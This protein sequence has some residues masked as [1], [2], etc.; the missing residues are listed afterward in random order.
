MRVYLLVAGLFFF[1]ISPSFAADYDEDETT[2]NEDSDEDS[3]TSADDEES[4]DE[5]EDSDNTDDSEELQQGNMYNQN[6]MI[7]QSQFIQ[8]QNMMFSQ[9]PFID[10][11]GM[12]YQNGM[13]PNYQDPNGLQ[14]NMMGNY[15]DP[16]GLQNGMLMN[17][18][19][20]SYDSYD[21]SSEATKAHIRSIVNSIL[22]I[23]VDGSN[24]PD[25][26][27]S[28]AVLNKSLQDKLEKLREYM[29]EI[30]QESKE[31]IN[32]LTQAQTNC[33][34]SFLDKEV[35]NAII[36]MQERVNGV[37]QSKIQRYLREMIQSLNGI[38]L[39][40][41]S[42]VS[43]TSAP[44][45]FAKAKPSPK[46][47]RWKERPKK[48]SVSYH[49]KYSKP[50]YQKGYYTVK[51]FTPENDVKYVPKPFSSSYTPVSA[52]PAS[53]EKAGGYVIKNWGSQKPT[54]SKP[55]TPSPNKY[56]SKK[57]DCNCGF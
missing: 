57:S 51:R 42:Y 17:N 54:T 25:E 4:E 19:L 23:N 16:N 39:V 6:M 5:D 35:K 53:S 2:Y 33:E 8:D 14:N 28:K 26:K 49:K 29:G 10:Q 3:S 21:P 20:N 27:D 43:K 37:L 44:K 52:T 41:K 22:G 38:P 40:K 55:T 45:K 36:K 34:D 18:Q 12:I 47:S 50:S 13:M 7:P 31:S 15:Q 48:R 30:I 1:M 9:Q 56:F 32:N 11:N 46:K 24:N